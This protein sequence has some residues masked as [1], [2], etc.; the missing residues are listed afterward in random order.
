MELGVRLNISGL[1]MAANP[2]KIPGVMIK[3]LH[4]KGTSQPLEVFRRTAGDF[5]LGKDLAKLG[6]LKI[7]E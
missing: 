2:G 3:I 7:K 1:S 6:G 5:V 4:V